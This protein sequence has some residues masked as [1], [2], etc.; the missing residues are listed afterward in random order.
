MF[1]VGYAADEA[2]FVLW[3]AGAYRNFGYSRNVQVTSATVLTAFAR[4]I[5]FQE[6]V[7]RPPCGVTMHEMVVAAT[8]DHL[9]EAITKRVA[10]TR[11]RL[12]AEPD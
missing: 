2:V 3:D 11:D 12:M 4:G 9:A 8:A 5:G 7:L 6:R 10:L 1:L